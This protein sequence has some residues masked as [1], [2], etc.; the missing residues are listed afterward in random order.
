MIILHKHRPL[1]FGALRPH[2]MLVSIKVVDVGT[3]VYTDTGG[4][5]GVWRG[6]V[7]REIPYTAGAVDKHS[8]AG[9]LGASLVN[10]LESF[11][12]EL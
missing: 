10:K 1:G 8:V 11:V 2:S 3:C 7:R 4:K 9:R 5:R 6:V 12:E